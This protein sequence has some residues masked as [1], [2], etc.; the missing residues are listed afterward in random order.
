V[1]N[2]T[3]RMSA[4]DQLERMKHTYLGEI[5]G[6]GQEDLDEK[7]GSIEELMMSERAKRGMVG[8]AAIER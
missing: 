3:V 1:K 2:K 5:Y 8:G 7:T 4:I 6:Q